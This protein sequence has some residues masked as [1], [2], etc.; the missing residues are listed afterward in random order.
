MAQSRSPRRY[1]L[2]CIYASGDGLPEGKDLA[3][4]FRWWQRA[5]NLGNAEAQFLLGVIFAKG[6][7]VKKSVADAMVLWRKAAAQGHPGAAKAVEAISAA[8]AAAA[9]GSAED[10]GGDA[11]GTEGDGASLKATAGGLVAEADPN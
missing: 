7:G 6:E 5:A 3:G 10:A 4:A 8:A 11:G 1:A 9:G 2:G